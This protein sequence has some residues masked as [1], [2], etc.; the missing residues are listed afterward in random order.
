M[1][2]GLWTLLKAV[3]WPKVVNFCVILVSCGELYHWQSYHIFFFFL[4]LR[5]LYYFIFDVV[6]IIVLN[7]RCEI[8]VRYLV[9]PSF[10]KVKYEVDLF[11]KTHEI[12]YIYWHLHIMISPDTL[13]STLRSNK[14]PVWLILWSLEVEI[15]NR[16]IKTFTIIKIKASV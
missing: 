11:L 2:Y 1:R 8:L 16:I 14:H 12:F 3:R 7:M 10:V 6:H 5:R 13:N 9:Q 15:I 4:Y